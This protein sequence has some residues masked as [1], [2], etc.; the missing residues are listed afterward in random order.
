MDLVYDALMLT[1]NWVLKTAFVAQLDLPQNQI[2]DSLRSWMA[3][4]VVEADHSGASIRL[5]RRVSGEGCA[6][7]ALVLRAPP[8]AR[9]SGQLQD[10]PA[11]ELASSSLQ[12][13]E[14]KSNSG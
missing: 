5:L 13:W 2:E 10:V 4:G 6:P 7:P 1:K 14:R 12:A 11:R 8:R 3:M 9:G